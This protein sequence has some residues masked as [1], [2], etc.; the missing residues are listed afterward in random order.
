MKELL[1]V[2]FIF[3]ETINGII[4]AVI[5]IIIG[6]ALGILG[7]L[8][9]N[10]LT[11]RTSKREIK[12]GIQT[13]LKE[14]QL[15]LIGICFSTTTDHG[16][17]TMDWSEWMLP[18]FKNFMNTDE[19]DYMRD[20]PFTKM[21]I[22]KSSFKRF[23]EILVAQQE[24]SKLDES[25]STM[26]FTKLISP[27]LDSKYGTISL[28]DEKYQMEITKLRRELISINEDFEQLQYYHYKTFDDIPENNRAVVSENI[29]II[30]KRISRKTK[31][32]IKLIENILL[33]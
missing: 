2:F 15:R 28:F 31:G 12:K 9:N 20:K 23:Y 10:K 32:I 7:T 1:L 8:I 17:I 18:Y 6:W 16:N 33:I 14:L 4:L 11:K 13:E 3:D 22:S 24:E 26:I 29:K 5:L 19:Y 30:L 25:K 27:Y 21:D